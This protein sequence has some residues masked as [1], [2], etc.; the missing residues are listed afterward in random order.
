MNS[1]SSTSSFR[2][3]LIWFLVAFSSVAK[4]D[5]VS[6]TNDLGPALKDCF[7]AVH[8]DCGSSVMPFAMGDAPYMRILAHQFSLTIPDYGMY[9]CDL[10]SERGKWNF[11]IVDRIVGFAK[12]NHM[13]VRAHALLYDYPTHRHHEKWTPTPKWVYEGRFSREEMIRIMDEH[14][15]TVMKRYSNSISQWIVVNEAVGNGMIGPMEDNIWL[16]GIGKDYVELAFARAHQVL[17][18]AELILNDYGADFIGQS[19]AGPFKANRFYEFV[20]VLREK[21]VPVDAVGL[22]FHLILDED[23]PDVGS[24]EKNFARYAALGLKVYVTELDVRV[25]EPVTEKKLT[26]QAA[27]YALVMSTAL[28]STNCAGVSVWDYSDRYSWITTFHAFPG[29]TDADLFDK[30]LRPK[31]A[32]EAVLRACGEQMRRKTTLNVER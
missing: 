24:I 10:Q 26:D 6:A 21:G 11:E 31:K 20:K 3:L 15:E 12:T 23:H 22:Q 4:G 9:M 2:F 16:H 8:K 14:I 17:P 19:N 28:K 7:L 25:K 1:F 32:V 29:Y 13:K 5:G 18:N 30:E 27:L